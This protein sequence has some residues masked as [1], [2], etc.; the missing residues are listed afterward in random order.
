MKSRPLS[1]CIQSNPLVNINLLFEKKDMLCGKG[2]K[3]APSSAG[4]SLGLMRKLA[5]A[6][7]PADLNEHPAIEPPKPGH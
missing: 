3:P 6:P 2:P 5:P 7:A 4:V 1:A